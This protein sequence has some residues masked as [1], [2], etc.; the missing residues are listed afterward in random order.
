MVG[1]ILVVAQSGAGAPRPY[2]QDCRVREE[3]MVYSTDQLIQFLKDHKGYFA[4]EFKVKKI[5]LL[6]ASA[7]GR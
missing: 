7:G 5:G 4:N 3:A 2:R 1:A 6:G